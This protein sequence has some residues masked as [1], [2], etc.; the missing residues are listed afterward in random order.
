[1]R[2]GGAAAARS[3]GAPGSA[4]VLSAVV[5]GVNAARGPLLDDVA[6]VAAAAAGLDRV[7]REAG[8]GATAAA[9]QARPQVHGAATDAAA[10]LGRLTADE[11]GYDTALVQLD[12]AG[13]VAG[14][15]AGQRRSLASADSAGRSELA[16]VRSL[17]AALGAAWPD[18]AGLDSA[19]GTW[20]TRVRGGW[21]RSPTEATGAYVVLVSD[22]RARLASERPVVAAA[23]TR[24][25]QAGAS[26]AAAYAS[27]ST[28]LAEG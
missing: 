5:R 13:T 26:A 19:Q 17:G 3:G 25:G 6:A 8:S 24:L 15:D 12:K 20:L 28:A 11:T 23:D 10:G 27:A 14:L 22:E 7:D 18:Y 16:A 4:A 1:M 21:Y 9:E 2:P